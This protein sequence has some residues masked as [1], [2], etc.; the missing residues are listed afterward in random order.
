MASEVFRCPACGQP[1]PDPFGE[2][3]PVC[4]HCGFHVQREQ[5]IPLLVRD[6][7]TLQ[8]T[9]D[10]LRGSGRSD[11]Y[12]GSQEESY[13]GPFR[14][15]LENRRRYLDGALRRFLGDN[16]KTRRALDLGCGDGMNLPWLRSYASEIHASDYNLLRLSRARARVPEARVFLASILDY[17]TQ[18]GTFDLVFFN[19]VLEHIP[20]DTAALAQA[21]RILAPGGL[22]VLGVPNEGALFWQ[23]AYKLSPEVLATSDH[24]H[25]YTLGHLRR[26]CE[27]VGFRIR[28]TKALGW[29]VPH[30]GWDARLKGHRWFNQVMDTVGPVLLPGQASSLYLLLTR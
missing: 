5:G 13:T 27:Q 14:F 29:G 24:V 12:E 3:P 25:F 23:L 30:W 2:P 28:E 11:W 18:D 6:P 21:H 22:L 20:D 10:T 1:L 9:I 16:A 7:K 26:K 15:H 4:S 19:H 8:E 17:P